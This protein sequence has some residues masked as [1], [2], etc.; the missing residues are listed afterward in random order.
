MSTKLPGRTRLGSDATRGLC[1]IELQ[2]PAGT[3]APT[4]ATLIGIE[5]IGRHQELL[6]GTG[7]DWGAGIGCLAIV[8]AHVG[9]VERVVGLE[10]AEANVETA[11]R[12][13]ERCGVGDR[14]R[15]L[16]AD[17]Y[18]P[19][20]DSDLSFVS[21]LE[22]A[23]DFILANPPSSSPHDDGFEFRRVVVRGAP[24]FL[25]PGGRIFLN[26]SHQY[27]DERVQALVDE[28]PGLSYGGV[29]ASTDWV[30]FDMTRPDLLV[31]V[32]GYAAE[33]GRGGL[34]YSFRYPSDSSRVLTAQEAM[35]LHDQTGRSPLSRWRSHLFTWE[36]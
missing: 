1:D 34:S 8:A 2:H 10:L 29:L 27:G 17:S 24:R 28:A 31:D 19:F 26:V 13:A 14:V 35:E 4:Q 15:F 12:N 32:T 23:V 33:E 11:S 22:G 9:A 7:I 18:E 20:A 36:G 16:R 30:P 6:A 5:A 3:F 25:K 21:T